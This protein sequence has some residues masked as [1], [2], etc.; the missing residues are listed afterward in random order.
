MGSPHLKFFWGAVPSVALSP[1]RSL[2]LPTLTIDKRHSLLKWKL[3][4]DINYCLRTVSTGK[5]I[6]ESDPGGMSGEMS[7]GMSGDMS[8][9]KYPDTIAQ[10]HSCFC[11]VLVYGQ[12]LVNFGLFSLDIVDIIFS[13]FGNDIYGMFIDQSRQE[14]GI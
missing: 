14:P 6:R 11:E 7:K 13:V 1:P 2:P 4:D 8:G 9:E 12:T 5:S 10:A 3:I